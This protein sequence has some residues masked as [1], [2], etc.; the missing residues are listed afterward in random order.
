MCFEPVGF[1]E[2]TTMQFNVHLAR[3]PGDLRA[4]EDAVRDADPAAL[5]DLDPRAPIL[6]VSSILDDSDLVALLNRAGA[7]VA[8]WDV[9]R[10][11]ANCCGGCGG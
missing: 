8:L 4:L 11:P 7:A 6:R 3:L 5:L 9:E 10:V 2:N 1:E